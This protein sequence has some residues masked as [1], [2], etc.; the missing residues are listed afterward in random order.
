MGQSREV[1]VTRLIIEDSIEHQ[2][3]KSRDKGDKLKD[4][5]NGDKL[6]CHAPGR[7]HSAHQPAHLAAPS[8]WF[9]LA[10]AAHRLTAFAPPR[11]GLLPGRT[12]MAR[13]R[14]AARPPRTSY[15]YR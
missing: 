10:H 4:S 3:M 13:E 15:R 8:S 14:R 2:I 12:R 1:R 5:K 7:P 9:P 11:P 6:V